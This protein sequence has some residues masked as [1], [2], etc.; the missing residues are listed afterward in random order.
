MVQTSLGKKQ[1]IISKITNPL[2]FPKKGWRCGSTGRAPSKHKALCSNPNTTKINKN[3][4]LK[5]F[6]I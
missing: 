6:Q 4:F 1:D 5:R 2:P 3:I